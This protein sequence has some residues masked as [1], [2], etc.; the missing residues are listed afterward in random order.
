MLLYYNYPSLEE[1]SR[2]AFGII[3]KEWYDR[4]KLVVNGGNNPFHKLAVYSGHDF[5]ILALLAA[6][7]FKKNISWPAYSSVV[8]LELYQNAHQIDS[9]FYLR[10]IYNG[11]EE[12]L[13]FCENFSIINYNSGKLCPWARVVHYL[14]IIT[15]E[16]ITTECGSDPPQLQFVVYV[17]GIVVIFM[18]GWI[19]GWTYALLGKLYFS[20]KK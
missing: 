19:F 17:V 11:K 15:P 7:G 18:M 9:Q 13:P 12:T 20:E 1:R 6:L 14:D 8:Q 16:N 3:L 2:V 10:L 4:W 5:G